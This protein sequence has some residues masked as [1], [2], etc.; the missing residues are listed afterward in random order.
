M[1]GLSRQ[2]R[3]CCNLTIRRFVLIFVAPFNSTYF[4]FFCF[5]FL[6]F[7]LFHIFYVILEYTM[8]GL[9]ASLLSENPVILSS[10]FSV[11]ELFSA[12]SHTYILPNTTPPRTPCNPSPFTSPP[13]NPP[14]LSPTT[15]TRPPPPPRILSLT[16]PP[17]PPLSSVLIL[18]FHVHPL[19]SLLTRSR[20]LYCTVLYCTL[21][22][23]RCR[24]HG[25][26]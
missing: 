4:N 25:D 3:A 7:L 15:T 26:R 18:S 19:S 2:S 17:P 5:Y 6:F 13:P 9:K 14:L 20:L 21:L 23:Y 24:L 8:N 1:H 16:P 22:Y 10:L 12:I 11:Q